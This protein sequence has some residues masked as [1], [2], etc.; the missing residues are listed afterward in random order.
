MT[1]TVEPQPLTAGGT[2]K[3]CIRGSTHG[4]QTV[5][6]QISNGQGGTDTLDV[7]LDPDGSGCA[8]WTVPAWP[9]AEFSYSTC[10]SVTVPIQ[11]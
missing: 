3:V 11:A 7:T 2:A 5:Q 10:P 8:D 1:I 6:V 9:Q 4:G